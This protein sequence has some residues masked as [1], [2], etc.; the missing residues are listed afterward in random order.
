MQ[1]PEPKIV[2][3]PFLTMARKRGLIGWAFL[4]VA[5]G[6]IILTSFYPFV[7]AVNL[8]LQT[9]AGARMTYAD[10]LWFNFQRLFVDP[11]LRQ[12]LSNT[13]L[14]LIIQVP[15]M[16]MLG[17]VLASMLN[18]QTL[19]LRGGVPHRDFSPLRCRA[20]CLLAHFPPDVFYK[21]LDKFHAGWAWDP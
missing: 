20:C 14:F 6:M 13:F 2:H 18:D 8:A 7:G 16:I 4:S 10:P 5:S 17:L 19:K 3:K 12:V 11:Q 9:G 21:R 15:I 1:K